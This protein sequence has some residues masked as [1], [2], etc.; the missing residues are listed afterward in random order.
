MLN[1]YGLILL[2]SMKADGG[3]EDH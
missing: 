1:L 3:G 2:A